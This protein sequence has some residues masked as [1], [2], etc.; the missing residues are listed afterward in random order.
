MTGRFT[1]HSTNFI[2]IISL[3]L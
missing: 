3:C 1:E 2:L